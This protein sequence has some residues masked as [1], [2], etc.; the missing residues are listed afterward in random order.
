MERYA[1]KS[2]FI[3]LLAVTPFADPAKSL[4]AM[5]GFTIIA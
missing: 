4:N 2:L 1:I 3:L 5:D